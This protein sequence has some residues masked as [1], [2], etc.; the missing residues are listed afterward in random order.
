MKKVTTFLFCVAA[1]MSFT[2]CN[3]PTP[4]MALKQADTRGKTISALMNND[5]YMKEVM[6]SMRM[7]HGGNMSAMGNGNMKMDENMMNNMMEQ[8]KTDPAMC[9]MMMDKTMAMCDG[10]SSMCRMMMTSMQAHPNM[11]KSM[12]GMKDMKM[13][14]MK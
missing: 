4:N 3:N 10:D 11:M 5:V 9:K 12:E 2:Q 1:L 13:N 14:K 8:C 7:K 6:D